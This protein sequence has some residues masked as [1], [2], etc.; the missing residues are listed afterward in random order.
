MDKGKLKDSKLSLILSD[1]MPI[2]AIIPK[3]ELSKVTIMI[4]EANF[5]A[6]LCIRRDDGK[7]ES[8][9][10]EDD[11]EEKEEEKLVLLP[12]NKDNKQMTHI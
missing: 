5:P 9:T 6:S 1:A 10:E 2:V 11:D 4:I 7:E 8:E 3:K 12:T